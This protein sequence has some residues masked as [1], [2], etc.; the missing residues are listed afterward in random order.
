MK[1]E[2]VN[3]LGNLFADD[4]NEK[5]RELI[6]EI[7]DKIIKNTREEMIDDIV[8]IEAIDDSS[9][10]LPTINAIDSVNVYKQFLLKQ[11]RKK[12]I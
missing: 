2:F 5:A 12:I 9:D 7:V 4:F 1:E 8:F 6:S 11:L 10:D 3:E